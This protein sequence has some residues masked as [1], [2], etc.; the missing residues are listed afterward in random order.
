MRRVID[1]EK[2]NA[3]QFFLGHHI[4][5]LRKARRFMLSIFEQIVVRL[6]CKGTGCLKINTQPFPKIFYLI[7]YFH[8]AYSDV[9]VAGVTF[10]L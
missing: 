10:V 8:S 4:T 6:Q 2:N 5:N 3:S 1:K 7:K 9:Q